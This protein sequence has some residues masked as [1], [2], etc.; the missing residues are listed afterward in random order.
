MP[1]SFW[2]LAID[3]VVGKRKLHSFSSDFDQFEHLT[4]T[5]F[6]S[7]RQLILG[8]SQYTTG[9]ERIRPANRR[10]GG[11]EPIKLALAGRTHCLPCGYR[12]DSPRL[13]AWGFYTCK[14]LSALDLCA[15]ERS[16]TSVAGRVRSLSHSPSPRSTFMTPHMC[17]KATARL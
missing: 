7:L 5:Y 1:K 10:H 4:S 12:D 11:C 2:F 13:T 14:P 9:I 3:F 8:N 17:S 6:R 15:R 16:N